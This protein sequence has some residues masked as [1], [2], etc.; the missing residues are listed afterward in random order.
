M[1][2]C[3]LDGTGPVG[4]VVWVTMAALRW[5]GRGEDFLGADSWS[6]GGFCCTGGPA[7][8]C[9]VYAGESSY[10]RR[11]TL[12]LINLILKATI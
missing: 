4:R 10:K 1:I 11:L 9:D 6:S 7:H 3:M 12:T 5:K 2:D 8:T